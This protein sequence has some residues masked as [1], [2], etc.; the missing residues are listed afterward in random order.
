MPVKRALSVLSRSL[1][2]S[3]VWSS[4][5]QGWGK[6]W[7]YITIKF[8]IQ[9]MFT[10][11]NRQTLCNIDNLGLV[12]D[13]V[14]DLTELQS[15]TKVLIHLSKT[16]AFYRRPSVVSKNISFVDSQTPLSP[17]SVLKYAPWTRGYN[18]EKGRG[19][20]M[21]NWRLK[22]TTVQRNRSFSGSVSTAFVHDCRFNDVPTRLCHG[23]QVPSESISV[24]TVEKEI[25]VCPF[26]YK[27]SKDID[28]LLT[29]IAFP[30]RKVCDVLTTW[31][32]HRYTLY[33]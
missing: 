12:N 4:V 23:F 21:W 2:I 8:D 19:V 29:L 5:I 31:K 3:W 16:N 20:E 14:K 13:D 26:S 25:W 1:C 7:L 32:L 22:N 11:L 28:W 24:C 10:R 30:L 17:F 9:R 15:W 18:I 33:H 27:P 6:E